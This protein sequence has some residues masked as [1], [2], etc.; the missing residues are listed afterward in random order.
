MLNRHFFHSDFE[1]EGEMAFYNDY[2]I[3]QS[4][5]SIGHSDIGST[6]NQQPVITEVLTSQLPF[7]RQP[8]LQEMMHDVAGHL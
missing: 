5:Q 2:K 1:G 6:N 7:R 8:P 4:Q 3:L